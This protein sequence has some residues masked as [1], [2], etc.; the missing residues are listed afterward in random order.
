MEI[1]SNTNFESKHL[2]LTTESFKQTHEYLQIYTIAITD[3]PPS[4]GP[5]F[6]IVELCPVLAEVVFLTLLLPL[7]SPLVLVLV[8]L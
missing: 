1:N 4:P 7:L 2:F 3:T 5:K 8:E 6:G